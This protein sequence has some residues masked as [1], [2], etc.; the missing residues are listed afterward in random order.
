MINQKKL[1]FSKCIK[2]FITPGKIIKYTKEI[3]I[4]I[5][6]INNLKLVFKI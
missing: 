1:K 5:L 4:N 3:D 6:E 2:N